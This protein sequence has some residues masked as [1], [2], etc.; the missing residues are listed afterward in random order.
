MSPRL[1]RC[2][3]GLQ[4]SVGLVVLVEACLLAFEPGRIRA[5]EHAGL[6]PILRPILV[7]GEIL[8]AALYLLPP[9]NRA[10]SYLLLGVFV[11]AAAAH[12]LHGQYDV[13][14]LIIYGMAVVVT[15]AYQAAGAAEV[16]NDR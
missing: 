11:L 14:A 1:K 16:A 13:G 3:L 6:P 12:I 8:A 2:L 9:T 7:G 10:G 4:W 15:L 5:F